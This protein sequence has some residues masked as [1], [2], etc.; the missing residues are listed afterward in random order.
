M[1][2]VKR[3]FA[4]TRRSIFSAQAAVEY[5]D[6]TR[7]KLRNSEQFLRELDVDFVDINDMA[8]DGLFHDDN[9]RCRIEEKLKREK[10]DGLFVPHGNFGDVCHRKGA[11]EIRRFLAVCN[12]VRT[13]RNIRILRIGLRPLRRHHIVL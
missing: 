1:A 10:V 3:G 5:A 2:A 7:N 6:Y 9:D 13:F 11:E 12:V 4:P 8:A